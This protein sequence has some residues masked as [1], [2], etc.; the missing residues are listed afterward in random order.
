MI[1]VTGG[2]GYIG[3][4]TVI[5]LINKG[6]DVVIFDNLS[7]G[8]PEIVD[9][10]VNLSDK[11]HFVEGDLRNLSQLE[12]LFETYSIESV[13]HF[14][15]SALVNE[16]VKNPHKYYD[17]N[18][19]G[20][21]NLFRIMIKNNVK[22]IVFSS[23]CATYGNPKYVPIDEQH[24]QN[25]INPYGQTKLT[26]EKILGDYDSA[27]GLKSIKLRYFNVAGADSKVRIGE[28]HDVETHLVPNIL[29]SVLGK[30]NT[31]KIFGDDYNTEDGTCIRDYVNV[32]DLAEAHYLALKYL[33]E[34]NL[35]DVFNI[36]THF[37][38]SVKDV[39]HSVQKTLGTDISYCIYPRRDGDPERLYADNK[40]ALEVL[41]WC[42]QKN[43]EH[44]INT[45]YEWEKI[46][47]TVFLNCSSGFSET[48]F[49]PAS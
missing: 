25:P 1:L 37:G 18:V 24:P 41:K 36:G 23:T 40:K 3:S 21:M 43:L 17:N 39:L 6:L 28:W 14:A 49:S 29:K 32:E 7:T 12:T 35:S 22:K 48:G 9:V 11:V 16:S 44:S 19:I 2:A 38:D 47:Q 10:L 34:K 15:G 46:L 5:N 13:M 45:A 27:Y 33:Q 30:E 26:V 4:H 8:H 42:P 20:S 31:F